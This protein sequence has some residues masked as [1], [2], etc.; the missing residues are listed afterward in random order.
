M[1]SI[2][3]WYFYTLYSFQCYYKIMTYFPVLYNIFFLLIYSIHLLSFLIPTPPI[4]PLPHFLFSLVI[5]SLVS[6]VEKTCSSNST[7]QFNLSKPPICSCKMDIIKVY[8]KWSGGKGAQGM[9]PQWFPRSTHTLQVLWCPLW[10]LPL[11][12]F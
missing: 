12:F 9:A 10:F 6:I 2:V 7:K 3:I 8:L 4:L 11:F 5:T 1:D